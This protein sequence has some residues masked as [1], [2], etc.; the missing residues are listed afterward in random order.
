MNLVF[1]ADKSEAFISYTKNKILEE[2]KVEPEQTSFL[3]SLSQ[4]GESNLFGETPTAVV[5]LEDTDAIK[6]AVDELKNIL[7]DDPTALDAGLIITTLA[8]RTGTKT[9]EKIIAGAGGQV[10]L[11]KG[12][13]KE[14]ASEKLVSELNLSR[15]SRSFL[16]SY[17][18]DD[19][20]AALP[21]IK[22]I[23]E[24]PHDQQPKITEEQ[25]V[26][27]MPQ[28]KGAVAPW[29]IIDPILS[30]NMTQALDVL[31]RTSMHS[32]FLVALI[33]IKNNMTQA[34]SIAAMLTEDSHLTTD[35][36]AA[37][38]GIKNGYG[39]IV[40]L[41]RAKKIGLP[42]LKR[43]VKLTADTEAKVKGGWGA[44]P[45]ITMESFIIELSMVLGGLSQN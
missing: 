43:A 17:I 3:T 20:E 42:T 13:G 14:T 5:Q 1:I 32:H 44:D 10:V 29:A 39:L 21:L 45:T 18:G 15:A 24:V 38:L 37:R 31:R 30:G 19:Y 6:R 9:L 28:P 23:S 12:E 34:F 22:S 25:L 16:L 33:T 8:A 40:A 7:A 36:V 2:W 35:D 26:L 41:R 4:V 27:R 11:S